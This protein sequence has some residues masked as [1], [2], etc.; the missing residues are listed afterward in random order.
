M[1]GNQTDAPF[2]CDMAIN[3]PCAPTVT[4]AFNI[5]TGIIRRACYNLSQLIGNEKLYII[6]LHV[7]PK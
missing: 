2:I 1:K 6:A 5:V 7:Q 4:Q 3:S